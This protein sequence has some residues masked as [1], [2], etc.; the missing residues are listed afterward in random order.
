[1][2][3]TEIIKRLQQTTGKTFL[4][5]SD[6]AKFM[7]W[8]RDKTRNMLKGVDY[9]QEK[10]NGRKLYFVNDIAERIMQNRYVD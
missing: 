8:G 7:G 6:L 10:E 5:I 4:N 1:M 2:T 3:K 9:Y